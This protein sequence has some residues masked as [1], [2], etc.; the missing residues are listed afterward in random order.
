LGIEAGAEK[1]FIDSANELQFIVENRNL[2]I[3]SI[4]MGVVNGL[5]AALNDKA[6]NSKINEV[7][8]YLNSVVENHEARISNLEGRLTWAPLIDE[9]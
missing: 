3:K 1:N 2:S 9:I 6:S 4:E 7:E 8:S 5:E